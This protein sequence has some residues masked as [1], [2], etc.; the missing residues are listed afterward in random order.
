MLWEK[1]DPKNPQK[2]G[3][4]YLRETIYVRD[5]RAYTRKPR[6][7]GSGDAYKNRHKYSLKKDIYCGKIVEIVPKDVILF[8]TYIENQGLDYTQIKIKSRFDELLHLFVDYLLDIHNLD[9]TEFYEGKKIAYLIANGY[10]SRE[11]I[12]F[13]KRFQAKKNPETPKEIQRFAFRCEDA[14][15]YDEDIIMNLY[16][17]IIPTP[18]VKDMKEE[19]GELNKKKLIEKQFENFRDFM[20]KEYE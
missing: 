17:K 8:K 16:I 12:D 2:G 1:K 3:Y 13:I 15:I 11:T 6:K 18:D 19:I 14:G 20:R 10:L 5:K 4:L 9:K 7:L